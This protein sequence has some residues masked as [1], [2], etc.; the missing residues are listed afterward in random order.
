MNKDTV[1]S[2]RYHEAGA[3]PMTVKNSDIAEYR[4]WKHVEL[5]EMREL[6]DLNLKKYRPCTR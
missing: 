3:D 4:E 6:A 2:V 5:H 1:K